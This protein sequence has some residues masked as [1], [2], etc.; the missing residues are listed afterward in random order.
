MEKRIAAIIR[1]LERCLEAHKAGELESALM[2]VECARADM[3]ILRDG[4]WSKLGRR[5][6]AKRRLLFAAA[7]FKVGLGTVC[8]ILATATPLALPPERRWVETEVT[9][10]A[11]ETAPKSVLLA[12]TASPT[13][14]EP[15]LGAE[16]AADLKSAAVSERETPPARTAV[17]MAEKRPEPPQADRQS[18]RQKNIN[19]NLSYENILALVQTGEKA[20]KNERPAI[21]IEIQNRRGF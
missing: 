14:L 15:A 9:E 7:L 1:W 17:H 8:A 21:E 16:P 4:V 11:E 10:K 20:L 18:E 2:D 13:A 19:T 5:R 3:D 6:T 12:E